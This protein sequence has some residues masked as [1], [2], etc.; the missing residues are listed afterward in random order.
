MKVGPNEY[1]LFMRI[2]SNTRGHVQWFN[3]TIRNNSHKKIKLNICN[4]RKEKTLFHR[5]MKPYVLSK[6]LK[7][8]RGADWAQ[9]GINVKFERQR[10]R[11]A[12]LEEENFS[13]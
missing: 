10:L 12:L 1:D 6:F 8:T 4:F 3:F 7:E 11:Y 13:E 9:G 2:D 5:G